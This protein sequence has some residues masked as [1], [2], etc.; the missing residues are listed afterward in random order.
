MRVEGRNPSVPA[1]GSRAANLSRHPGLQS[2][3]RLSY[4]ISSQFNQKMNFEDESLCHNSKVDLFLLLSS[5]TQQKAPKICH[6][7]CFK[8][9]PSLEMLKRR[10]DTWIRSSPGPFQPQPFEESMAEI[11]L[12]VQ[13]LPCDAEAQKYHCV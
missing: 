8:T 7:L 5:Y 2:A 12:K 10:A 9:F 4:K 6:L 11:R 13:I 1:A 3:F